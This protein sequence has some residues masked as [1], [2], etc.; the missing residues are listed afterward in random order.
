MNIRIA[1]L[2]DADQM[3]SLAATAESAAQWSGDSY[4][5]IF[6]EPGRLALVAES[7]NHLVGFIVARTVADQWEIEN[8]VVGTDHRRH[9]IGTQLVN[10]VI[11]AARSHAVEQ[12]LLEVRESNH[13]A[14]ALYRKLGFIESGRRSG[15]YSAPSE[16]AILLT[17]KLH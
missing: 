16:G 7:D 11:D 2:A 1:A 17:L 12:L 13:T 3:P 15:Y 10:A 14:R 9:G 5:R 6:T 8:V 4:L